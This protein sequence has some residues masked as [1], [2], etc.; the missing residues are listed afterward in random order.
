MVIVGCPFECFLVVRLF[1]A[2]VNSLGT[3]RVFFLLRPSL[4][5]LP[6][7]F[8]VSGREVYTL[9]SKWMEQYRVIIIR[10]DEAVYMNNFNV[11]S[12][13]FHG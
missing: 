8:P 5:F 2:V 13:K 6:F 11:P 4:A 1:V 9:G 12:P 3:A 10:V 7:L